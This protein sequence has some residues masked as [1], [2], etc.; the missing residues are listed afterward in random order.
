MVL[1][2][3]IIIKIIGDELCF[4]F[5]CL[6]YYSQGIFGFIVDFVDGFEDF[7]VCQNVEDIVVMVI[8]WLCVEVRIDSDRRKVVV[9]WLNCK[10][11]F[12][13]INLYGIQ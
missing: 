3:N 1:S 10:D 8:G 6:N 4:F 5:I 7:K 13:G 12:D 9:I 11:V 2:L